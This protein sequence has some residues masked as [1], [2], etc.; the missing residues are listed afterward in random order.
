MRKKAIIRYRDIE[1]GSTRA[2]VIVLSE[3]TTIETAVSYAKSLIP[4]RRHKNSHEKTEI[5]QITLYVTE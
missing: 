1:T 3:H 4:D 5:V 2:F